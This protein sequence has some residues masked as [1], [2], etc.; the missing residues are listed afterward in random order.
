MGGAAKHMRSTVPYFL[1]GEHATSDS[2]ERRN[3][4]KAQKRMELTYKPADPGSRDYVA[5]LA[6]FG[7]PADFDERITKVRNAHRDHAPPLFDYAP[8]RIRPLSRLGLKRL[9]LNRAK[10][11]HSRLDRASDKQRE[12]LLLEIHLLKQAHYLV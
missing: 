3:E 11:L 2:R 8:G 9:Y 1:S 4:T 6:S 12:Q 10:D 5:L 7:L